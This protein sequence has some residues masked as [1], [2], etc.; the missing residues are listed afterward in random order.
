MTDDLSRLGN[1]E[2]LKFNELRALCKELGLP[3]SGYGDT[4]SNNTFTYI[5]TYGIRLI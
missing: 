3:A 2:C 4:T 5:C 1:V